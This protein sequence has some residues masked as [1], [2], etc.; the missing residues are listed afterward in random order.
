MNNQTCKF[1][2]LVIFPKFLNVDIVLSELG[3]ERLRFR[4]RGRCSGKKSKDILSSLIY[5]S[6]SL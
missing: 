2:L 3:S 5:T 4:I 6:V 1:Y